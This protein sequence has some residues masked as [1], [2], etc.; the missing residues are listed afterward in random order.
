MD[1]SSRPRRHTKGPNF[2]QPSTNAVNNTLQPAA[3][4]MQYRRIDD[5]TTVERENRAE[6]KQ[7]YSGKREDANSIEK[8]VDIIRQHAQESK[9][10]NPQTPKGL[11][12]NQPSSSKSPPQARGQFKAFG[13]EAY[14]TRAL[15]NEICRDF[16][17]E[18]LWCRRG[19]YCYRIHPKDKSYYISLLHEARD[20]TRSVS[21]DATANEGQDNVGTE[22]TKTDIEI[23]QD[24]VLKVKLPPS[25]SEGPDWNIA[26][27]W[28]TFPDAEAWT[29]S[30]SSSGD[31]TQD[32]S[33]FS[34][35]TSSSRTS[36]AGDSE[37]SFKTVTINTELQSR[38]GR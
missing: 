23:P 32:S 22:A 31:S 14:P 19:N 29:D 36:V 4:V 20:E 6:P 1:S 16:I 38:K 25:S 24:P 21:Q 35:G 8:V 37:S 13:I 27:V 10:T 33:R 2:K 17:F 15:Q 9:R 3:V 18:F 26:G 34:S 30:S 12:V 11:Q 28:Q 7:S 5:D